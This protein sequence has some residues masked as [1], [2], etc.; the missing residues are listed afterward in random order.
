MRH[1]CAVITTT[2][3]AG[4][5]AADT[6]LDNADTCSPILHMIPCPSA[7]PAA[8]CITPAERAAAS[9]II[10]Q[11]RKKHPD[12]AGTPEPGS[13]TFYPMA[14]RLYGDMFVNNYVDLDPTSGILD[15][16][17]TNHTYDGHG[18]IDT[19][20]RSFSEQLIGVPAYAVL[21]G[22][23]VYSHDGEYDM[24]TEPLNV[25]AN[26]VIID[27]GND[28]YGHYWH[29]RNGS[30]S[31]VAGDQVVTG[32]QI[33]EVGSSGSSTAPHLHFELRSGIG[34]GNTY[35]PFAGSCHPV[36]SMWEDQQEFV[37]EF[38]FSDHGITATPFGDWPS[39][40][41]R[42]PNDRQFQLDDGN[43]YYWQIANN[44]PAT[45]SWVFRFYDPSGHL[46]H[47]WTNSW[48]IGQT[49]RRWI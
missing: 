32:Q 39:Y 27:H 18:G 48:D 25:P 9:V 44:V 4:S 15:W 16:D 46:A 7:S 45:G 41:Y 38:Y 17:C 10:E 8:P 42:F 30:V 29:F 13:L 47:E 43:T 11:Y 24:N 33:A 28:L 31:V 40:P 6:N 5:S 22:I 26:C 23:V 1:L 21:D 34:V 35:D 20:L 49:D 12:R 3:L 36:D 37:R 2:L 19:D 14:G